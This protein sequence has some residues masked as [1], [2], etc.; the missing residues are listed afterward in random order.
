MEPSRLTR[1]LAHGAEHIPGLRRLPVLKLLLVG[2]LL[3]LAR[4]HV[5]RLEPQERHRLVELL[6]VGHGRRRNLDPEQREELA[7][8]IEKAAPREF[9][10]EAVSR[11][12][13]VPVPRR[14]VEGRRRS[15]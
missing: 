6:R 4:Q 13:P 10:G 15:R 14:F 2:E 11:L 8:L 7:V 12:S 5:V 1:G 9:L 3:V